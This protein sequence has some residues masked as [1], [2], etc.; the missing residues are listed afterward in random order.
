MALSWRDS[1]E[2]KSFAWRNWTRYGAFQGRLP[3]FSLV[4][5]FF[6]VLAL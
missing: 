6:L 5:I 2:C 4:Q 1:K 3:Q